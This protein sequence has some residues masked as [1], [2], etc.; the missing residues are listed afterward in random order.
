MNF[1]FPYTGNKRGENKHLD[2]I[3]NPLL[4]TDTIKY[5]VEP[6]CGTASFSFQV[7]Q[8]Y[9]NKFKYVLNDINP[10]LM[11]MYKFIQKNG[12]KPLFDFVNEK[13]EELLKSQSTEDFKKLT[14]KKDDDIFHFFFYNRVYT[15]YKGKLYFNGGTRKLGNYDYKKWKERDEFIRVAELSQQSHDTFLEP[16]KNRDDVLVYCDPPY[17][18]SVNNYYWETREKTD[19]DGKIIDYTTVWTDLY[20]FMRQETPTILVTNYV[21]ILHFI[22]AEYFQKK[23]PKR[24]MW[25]NTQRKKKCTEHVVY[26]NHMHV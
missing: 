22:F 12:C 16:W 19:T 18:Q 6:F 21:S 7:F 9:G 8:K 11:E 2:E 15:H 13:V 14:A 5:I 17:F 23:Y 26:F 3:L 1:Y 25:A 4:I 24:Y 20:E 10:R